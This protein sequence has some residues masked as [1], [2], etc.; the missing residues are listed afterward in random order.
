MDGDLEATVARKKTVTQGQHGKNFPRL[1][2][3]NNGQA[4][5]S[6]KAQLDDFIEQTFPA[7]D[8]FCLSNPVDRVG[9]PE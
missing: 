1:K 4:S 2:Y 3:K 6:V 8:P 9:E 7:S 5:E